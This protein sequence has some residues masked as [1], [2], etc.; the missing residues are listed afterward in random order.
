M[1][2]RASCKQRLGRHAIAAIRIGV[3]IR[4]AIGMKAERQRCLNFLMMH[5]PVVA[6]RHPSRVQLTTNFDLTSLIAQTHFCTHGHDDSN[7]NG[8]LKGTNDSQISSRLPSFRE[9]VLRRSTL[10]WLEQWRQRQ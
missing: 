2:S 1:L 3:S 6:L 5:V 7:S 4:I 9:Q 8:D 10:L